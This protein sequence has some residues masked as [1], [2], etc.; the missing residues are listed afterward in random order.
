M[1]YAFG[2]K[3]TWVFAITRGEGNQPRVRS[4]KLPLKEEDLNRRVE[5][6][7]KALATR[8]LSYRTLARD[9]YRDLLGPLEADLKG[10]TI[11]GIV[12]DER[13][14]WNSPVSGSGSAG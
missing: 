10:R 7:R 13:C 1:E 2:D 3:E 8:D 6:F 5:A 11:V 14:L 4:K 9:L 12:P